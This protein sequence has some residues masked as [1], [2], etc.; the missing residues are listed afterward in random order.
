[1]VPSASGS[2]PVD[3]PVEGQA[4]ITALAASLGGRIV[5]GQHLLDQLPERV[6]N[7]PD[8]RQRFLLRPC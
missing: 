1:M 2:H 7:V 3:D 8:R 4:R 5:D 6:G